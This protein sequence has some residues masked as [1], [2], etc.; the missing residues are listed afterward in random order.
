MIEI[1]NKLY[2]GSIIDKSGTKNYCVEHLETRFSELL[3]EKGF[4]PIRMTKPIFS[5]E[6]HVCD[7]E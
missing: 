1:C 2:A 7:Y 5:Q 3:K 4:P 6:D